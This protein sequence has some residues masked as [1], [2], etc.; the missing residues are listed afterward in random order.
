[1]KSK[2]KEEV[3]QDLISYMEELM[4]D[5]LKS[6]SPK[7]MSLEIDA[8]KPEEMLD[9]I[10][11]ITAIMYRPIISEKT[12]HKFEIEEYFFRKSKNV[13]IIYEYILFLTSG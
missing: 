7:F 8:K 4:D 11:I 5:R 6:K 2:A 13:F 9:Y 3:L 12:K 10:H 1:M